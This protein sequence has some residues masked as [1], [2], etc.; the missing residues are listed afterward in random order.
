MQ[1]HFTE[2]KD[3]GFQIMQSNECPTQWIERKKPKPKSKP[4]QHNREISE[5]FRANEKI[6][7]ASREENQVSDKRLE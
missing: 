4:H 5:H 3:I 2:L 6:L 7:N 1:G